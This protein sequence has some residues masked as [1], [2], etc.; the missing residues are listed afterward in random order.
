MASPT[1]WITL[2]AAPLLL[3]ACVVAPPTGPSVMVLP[4][5]GKDLAQF[6]QEDATCRQ[7]AW[8][9]SGGAAP[10]QAASDSFINSAAL[11]TLLGGAAGAAIGAAAGN[12]AA[13]AAIGAGS[14]LFVGGASG[15]NAAA[16]SGASLQ[17]R[18]DIGYMQCMTAKGNITPLQAAGA[19]AETGG[20]PVFPTAVP[21]AWGPPAS[22]FW[23]PAWGPPVWGPFWGPPVASFWGPP[24]WGPSI[25][26]SFVFVNHGHGAFVHHRGAVFVRRPWGGGGW[27]GGRWGGGG[28]GGGHWGGGGGWHR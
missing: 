12:P 28:W 20:V 9:Q 25:G 19:P 13:G 17:Q 10:A 14:G 23:G 8:S 21:W 7:F 27:G 11:G 26:A 6:Q 2:V 16:Y 5:K 3:A 24:F 22:G 1:R 15:A 4:A 18:Y